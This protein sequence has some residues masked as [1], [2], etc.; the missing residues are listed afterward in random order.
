MQLS[1]R[2]IRLAGVS[3]LALSAAA[4]GAQEVEDN[5]VLDTITLTATTGVTVQ[6]E[7]YVSDYSQ[8][9]TKSD[10]PVAEAQQSIS[11]VST[12]QIEDQGAQTLGRALSYTA[13]VLGEPFGSDPRFDSP[14][15]RGFEASSG[16]YVNGL[17][18][19]RYLGAP[20]YE[21]YG[22]QQIEV[23]RGPSSSLYGAGTP[24][25]IINQVQKRA[26]DY[27]FGEVGLGYDSNE[28]AQLFFDMNRVVN[29]TLSWR[30]TGIGRDNKLQIDELTNER[31]YLAGALRWRPDDFTTVD[32]T[33]SYTKDSPISP[34]GVPYDLTR[35]ADGDYLRDLYTG[36]SDWDDSDRKVFNIGIEISHEMENGWTL[37]QGFRYEKFDWDYTGTYVS[38]LS[39]DGQQILLGY[40][41]QMEDT[42]G[43]NLDTR[44]SGEVTTG[45]AIHRLLFGV[46]IRKYDAESATD[47]FFGP[48]LDW[49][50]PVYSN[51][52]P[53]T[54]WYVS[55][56]DLTLEQIG[57]Y[58]QDEVE[59]GNWRGSL[60]LRRD[61]A[62]QS[63]TGYNNFAGTT[64]QDQNDNATTGRAGL[65]YVFQNGVMP[66]VSYSTSFDPEIGADGDGNKLKPTKGRQWEAGVKYQPQSFNGLFTV[67]VYDLR[68]TNVT[69]RIVEDGRPFD[70][71]IGKV[72]SRG[73]EMEGTAELSEGWNLRASYAYNDNEQTGGDFDG[74]EMSN[75]P[76]NLASLWLDRDFGNG[77]RVG[78]GIRHIG[79]RYG[80][81]ANEY[82]L[83]SVTMADLGASYGY[84]DFEMSLNVS[85][86]TDEEYVANCGTFGCF[87]GE[88]RTVTAKVSYKW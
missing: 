36:N 30:L 3:A 5:V 85:N 13:G 11:I 31:G 23:L 84:R 32:L 87:Y 72:K 59:W 38:G 15:I 27:D 40:N 75:A 70:R 26:Q 65:A 80:D 46:D 19:L 77:L 14:T 66:Y 78:G 86:L 54:P 25:G 68:E 45:D 1:F 33:A 48:G 76:R 67:A 73:I 9:A 18:Q 24:A 63:G 83:D 47:F 4:A 29:D 20:A 57:I 44:L 51:D 50:N 71:Q 55:T 39:E 74:K 17:R 58:A 82:E 8:A 6:A 16:Q 79:S 49:R 88:G 7:G 2:N 43:V 52:L 56:T 60:A 64:D 28:A 34:T 81:L 35:S 53:S 21:T 41:R 62:E 69:R 22:L 37:S 61:W 12:D 10:T 42:S